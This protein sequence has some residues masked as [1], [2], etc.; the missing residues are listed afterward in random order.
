MF[1]GFMVNAWIVATMVAAVAGVVGFFVVLR[2]N[3]FAAHALPL[4]IFPGAAAAAFVGMNELWGLVFF[5]GLGVAGISALG[6]RQRNDVATALTLIFLLGLGTLF[7]SLSREYAQGVYALLFGDVLGVS[8]SDIALVAGIGLL[9]MAV[10]AVMFR[11]LLLSSV[12][13]DLAAARG[14]SG[15]RVEVFFLAV[16][17][18]ATAMALPVVGALLVFSLMVG[19]ASAARLITRRPVAALFLSVLI[20]VVTVWA[21]LALSYESNWPA[22]F[23][24]GALAAGWY[25]IGRCW[26]KLTNKKISAQ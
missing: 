8:A 22:G 24:V 19:P 14:V 26:V 3:V 10:T 21:A 20:A 23:F 4:G 11:P 5:S 7:L 16:L 1:S 9:V 17:G 18:L 12:S 6:R 2:G 25:G 13:L 15:R